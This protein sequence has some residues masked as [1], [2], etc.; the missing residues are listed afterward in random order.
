L[1][2]IPSYISE[3]ASDSPE[4]RYVWDE[5]GSKKRV[6][7]DEG[8]ELL[9]EKM[10]RL[11]QRG[12]IAVVN[13][14]AEWIVCRFRLLLDVKDPLDAIE[15]AWAGEID[16]RYMLPLEFSE[17]QD[18]S[19]PVNGVIL[20]SLQIVND[21]VDLAWQNGETLHLT[22]RITNLARYVLPEPKRFNP[23]LDVAI[24]RIGEQSPSSEGDF[25]GDV[26]TRE[27]LDPTRQS[28]LEVNALVNQFLASITPRENRFLATQRMLI[29]WGF[30]GEPYTFS[31]NHDQQLKRDLLSRGSSA[32]Y[33]AE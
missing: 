2:T 26:V 11:S 25:L 12:R 8:D 9:R 31:K 27:T 32:L 7:K 3:A 33:A 5:W 16:R 4:I 28:P 30:Q 18:W 14:I 24:A 13:G 1:L 17:D 21:C 20:R 19:G 15:A 22:V 29:A 6:Y 23:W 10:S